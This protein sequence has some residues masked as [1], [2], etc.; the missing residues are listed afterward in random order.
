MVDVGGCGYVIKWYSLVSFLRWLFQSAQLG[1]LAATVSGD[2]DAFQTSNH[3][4]ISVM[5]TCIYYLFIL[6]EI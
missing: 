2:W 6:F 1:F 3:Q 5:K 4:V